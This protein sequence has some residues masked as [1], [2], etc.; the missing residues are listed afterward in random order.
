[1]KYRYLS[2]YGSDQE[3]LMDTGAVSLRSEA[4]EQEPV[5]T[6]ADPTIIGDVQTLHQEPSLESSWEGVL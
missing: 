1:M 6:M 3:S 2:A 4:S 5:R